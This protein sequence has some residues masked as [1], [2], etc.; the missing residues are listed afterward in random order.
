MAAKRKA[1]TDI[2]EIANKKLKSAVDKNDMSAARVAQAIIEGASKVK[3]DETS[4]LKKCSSLER[5][6][7]KINST[8]V[9]TL[10]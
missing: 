2:L 8:L 9:Q 1:Y 5:K 10:D 3:D 7:K 6:L 4:I